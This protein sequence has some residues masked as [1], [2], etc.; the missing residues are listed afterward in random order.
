MAATAAGIGSVEAGHAAVVRNELYQVWHKML[1]FEVD[2]W[3][4][5]ADTFAC[6]QLATENTGL[7]LQDGSQITYA[8]AVTA[9]TKLRD[10]LGL[11]SSSSVESPLTRTA[12]PY[13]N[14][15]TGSDQPFLFA[16]DSNA[17][18]YTR[19]PKQVTSHIYFV[20]ADVLC[21]MCILMYAATHF[22]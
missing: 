16:V 17:V 4:Y 21:Y 1:N 3:L 11:T 13:K 20:F 2:Y 9:I 10:T 12:T 18:A 15:P 7:T 14:A 19:T 22:V 5:D 8:T 6:L